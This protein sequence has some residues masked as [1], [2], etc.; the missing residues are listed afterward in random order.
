MR[1]I[2]ALLA[3]IIFPAFADEAPSAS[4]VQADSVTADIQ[5]PNKGKVIDIIATSNY[6]YIKVSA[7]GKSVW[8]AT[9]EATV[10]K[11][12]MISYND[13]PVTDSFYS[14][15]LKRTFKNVIFVSQVVVIK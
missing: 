2:A 4:Q 15:S 5:L 13:G 9:L 3:L 1:A 6:S 10:K 11:G 8:L 14:P 7:G 12:D